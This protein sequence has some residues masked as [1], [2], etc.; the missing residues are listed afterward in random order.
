MG[1]E[2]RLKVWEGWYAL[3][4]LVAGL[5]GK[6]G[7]GGGPNIRRIV[8]MSAVYRRAVVPWLTVSINS[9]RQYNNNTVYEIADSVWEDCRGDKCP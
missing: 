3:G 5:D 8:A 2:R 6:S 1:E 9:I 4:V 7:D